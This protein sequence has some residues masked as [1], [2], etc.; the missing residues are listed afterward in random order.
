[1]VQ[2]DIKYNY[3]TGVDRLEI[4]NHGSCTDYMQLLGF[5]NFWAY[6]IVSLKKA[7][8]GNVVSS[9]YFIISIVL[10]NTH[11][12]PHCVLNSKYVVLAYLV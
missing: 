2:R 8:S 6:N 11:L 4:I 5:Y 9:N 7:Y 1:M 3:L 12:Q 10:L